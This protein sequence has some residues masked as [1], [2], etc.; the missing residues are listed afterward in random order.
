MKILMFSPLFYP[1]IG[2]VE[3]HV[4]RLSEELVK[5][6]HKVS[7]ITR[8]HDQNLSDLEIKDGIYI[9]RIYKKASID[10]SS[11]FKYKHLIK[12]ADIIHLHDF[13]TFINWYFPFRFLYPFKKIFITFHGHEG[14]IPIPKKILFM[15]FISENLTR[16]N[17]CI[18]DFITKWYHTKADMILY[19]GVD[20][21]LLDTSINKKEKSAVFVGRLEK[22]TGI[23]TYVNAIK[24]LKHS[25]GIDL[26]T[27]I[28]G[29]G[30]LKEYIQKFAL[31]NNSKINLHG[32]V[33]DPSDYIARNDFAFVSGYLSILEAMISKKLVFSIYEN[34]LKKDYLSLIPDASNINIASSSDELAFQIAY[35]CKNPDEVETKVENA[36]YFAKDQTWEKVAISYLELW[37]IKAK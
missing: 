11:M 31:E 23:I 9:Y 35:Y 21:T 20:T 6:G 5:Y 26:E 13:S 19:G 3:K 8:K 34:D 18:G 16:G 28:C 14:I 37:S 36:Y 7:I 12:N 32:F 25:Y 24:I 30:S 2:G 17:I 15:R 29:D 22:D 4:L 1:H 10:W 27:D 33:K